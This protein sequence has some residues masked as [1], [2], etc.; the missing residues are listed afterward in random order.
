VGGA[1]GGWAHFKGGNGMNG[2]VSNTSNIWKTRL[3]LFHLCHSSHYNEPV[4]L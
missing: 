1:I 4:L 2:T 3:T